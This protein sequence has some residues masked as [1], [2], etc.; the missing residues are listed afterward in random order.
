MLSVEFLNVCADFA[1]VFGP[2]CQWPGARITSPHVADGD[3][4]GISCECDNEGLKCDKLCPL[5][6]PDSRCVIVNPPD[7]RPCDCHSYDCSEAALADTESLTA[8]H[9][10]LRRLRGSGSELFCRKAQPLP[11]TVCRTMTTR[12]ESYDFTRRTSRSKCI[13]GR[14]ACL[15]LSI[16]YLYDESKKGVSK[17][18]VAPDADADYREI[19]VRV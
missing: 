2:P 7:D 5:P 4:C 6:P 16:D 11:K 14:F 12:G 17:F 10:F 15:E 19:Q 9:P 1:T 18:L 13:P 3:M 8:L